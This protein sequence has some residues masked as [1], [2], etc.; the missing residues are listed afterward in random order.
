VGILDNSPWIDN[1]F[2]LSI[3]GV[4][5]A[6]SLPR[7]R[8]LKTHLPLDGIPYSPKAKYIY[9]VRDMRDVTWSCWNHWNAYTDFTF[10]ANNNIPG[11]VGPEQPRPG[12]WTVKFFD[13]MIDDKADWYPVYWS[14]YHNLIT[15]W[16]Y[17]HLPNVLL[18]HYE[19]MKQNTEM[20]VRKF[21][22]FLEI[23]LTEEG[24]SKIIPQISL[25]WM[26]DHD[27][28]VMGK[29][30]AFF[31]KG[32]FIN[33]GQKNYWQNDLTADDIEKYQEYSLKRLGPEAAAW[34]MT[35]EASTKSVARLGAQEL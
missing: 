7:R 22:E 18:V 24:L 21:A 29:L 11:R 32:K 8:F 16:Q 4:D 6:E 2:F 35:A 28:Q 9:V 17:R 1:R 19:E 10:N 27:V 20:I 14:C 13:L 31:E 34:M 23:E 33:K 5:I 12:N 3:G 30:S 26:K 25:Q 15:W